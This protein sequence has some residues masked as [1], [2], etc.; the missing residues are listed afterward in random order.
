MA[1]NRSSADLHM[2]T[3]RSDG[4]PTVRALLDQVARNTRLRV[5]A[6]TDHDT[7][8][9]AHEARA[10]QRYYP[11]EI[12]VGEEVSSRDGHILALYIEE[13]IAPGMSASET[14]TAIHEQGGL[15]VAAH[16]FF[17]TSGTGKP[18][19]TPQGVGTLIATLPFD[20]VEV[21]NA[22]PLLNWANF[23]A[24]RYNRRYQRLAE[25]GCSDAHIVEAIGKS[26]T[27]FPG[28]SAADLRQAIVQRRT[29]ARRQRYA[30]RELFTYGR[31]YL[32]AAS[33]SDRPRPQQG[34]P[35]VST[36]R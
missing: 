32:E 9:G 29:V 21:H 18:H 30:M 35:V 1:V 20:A 4:R 6:V 8:E 12:I 3:H 7:V 11:F 16:P 2:H 34:D 36:G 26:L 17:A 31:F 28:S 25:L 14:I 15:A 24:L 5:I 22:A 10:L 19:G 23:R 13:R 27:R 33:R